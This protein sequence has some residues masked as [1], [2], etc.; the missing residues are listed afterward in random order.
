MARLLLFNKPFHVLSQFTD[1]KGRSTLTKFLPSKVYGSDIYPAGRLDYDS[2]G[3]LLLTNQGQ[4]QSRIS[5]PR[6]KMWKT[7][8]VLV[9]GAPKA[10]FFDAIRQGVKLRDGHCKPGRARAIADPQ[11]WDRI[12]PVRHRASVPSHWIE[13]ELGEGRNRQVRR[14]CAALG[15]PVLRLVRVAVGDWSLG[16]LQPGEVRE[17][18]VN[19]PQQGHTGMGPKPRRSR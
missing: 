5:S 15:H 14:M 17:L 10:P 1:S 9:E 7:Y 2:E 12:P 19:L 8:N 3:L 13:V 11:L 6:F 4:L 18:A 16:T